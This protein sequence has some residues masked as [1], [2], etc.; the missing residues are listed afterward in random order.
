[1]NK[2]QTLYYMK[3]KIKL[4]ICLNYREYNFGMYANEN[5][6]IK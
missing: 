2:W 6:V 4:L 1:M 3:N 5:F